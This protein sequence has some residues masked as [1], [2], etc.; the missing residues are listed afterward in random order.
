MK[1]KFEIYSSLIKEVKDFSDEISSH[2]RDLGYENCNLMAGWKIGEVTVTLP[3]GKS[4]SEVRKLLQESMQSK[5]P[6]QNIWLR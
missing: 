4:V 6:T 2:M 5:V 3:K 1:I